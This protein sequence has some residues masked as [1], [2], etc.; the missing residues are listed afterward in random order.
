MISLITPFFLLVCVDIYTAEASGTSGAFAPDEEVCQ[1]PVT[2]VSNW[3][4]D[5]TGQKIPCNHTISYVIKNRF[6]TF[7]NMLEEVGAQSIEIQLPDEI[8]QHAAATLLST[9]LHDIEKLNESG[10]NSEPLYKAARWLG[11]K[12]FDEKKQVTT[13][14]RK[15]GHVIIQ[16]KPIQHW[17][18]KALSLIKETET[19]PLASDDHPL[20]YLETFMIWVQDDINEPLQSEAY[21]NFCNK[22]LVIYNTAYKTGLMNELYTRMYTDLY[23]EIKPTVWRPTDLYPGGCNLQRSLQYL[24]TLKTKLFASRAWEIYAALHGVCSGHRN[25]SQCLL[26]SDQPLAHLLPT[27]HL[28]VA[29]HDDVWPCEEGH[30]YYNPAEIVAQLDKNNGNN[31]RFKSLQNLR[32]KKAFL[33]NIDAQCYSTIYLLNIDAQILDTIFNT[34]KPGKSPSYLFSGKYDLANAYSSVEVEPGFL[35]LLYSIPYNITI[36]LGNVSD[37]TMQQL[38]QEAVAHSFS[39]QACAMIEYNSLE[40]DYLMAQNTGVFCQNARYH[41]GQSISLYSTL[42]KFQ[43]FFGFTPAAPTI[44]YYQF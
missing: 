9:K 13:F 11:I 6:T 24:A 18:L 14:A 12:V 4:N 10:Y 35:K 3:Y 8:C 26:Y 17:C 29:F 19:V 28:H 2:L 1:R 22:R 7:D 23:P 31:M 33:H 44:T 34:K 5:F 41:N 27:C 39:K 15:L 21:K 25:D 16:E 38:E 20:N 40:Y 37:K 36:N 43:N 30:H 32:N 42:D